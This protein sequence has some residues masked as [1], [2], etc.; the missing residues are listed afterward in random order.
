MATF[1]GRRKFLATLFGGAAATWPLAGPAQQ[2]TAIG[3]TIASEI[4]TT[5]ADPEGVRR[6]E[7]SPPGSWCRGRI[8]PAGGQVFC[9]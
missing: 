8:Q 5:V 3:P 9:I 7:S 1:I 4:A 6:A 2:P